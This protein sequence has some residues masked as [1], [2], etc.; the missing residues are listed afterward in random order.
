MDRIYFIIFYAETGNGC[1][2]TLFLL[3]LSVCL[4]VLVCVCVPLTIFITFFFFSCLCPQKTLH[5]T[6]QSFAPLCPLLFSFFTIVSPLSR[7]VF[8]SLPPHCEQLPYFTRIAPLLY[9]LFPFPL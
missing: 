1:P 4:V 9:F 5:P 8:L 2:S 3:R 7:L 6:N